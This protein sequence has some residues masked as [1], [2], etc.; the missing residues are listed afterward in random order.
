ML[1]LAVVAVYSPSITG[2]RPDPPGRRGMGRAT[3]SIVRQV[4]TSRIG[5]RRER[6]I[7]NPLVAGPSPAR[8]SQGMDA[9]VA[10]RVD[11]GPRL[12]RQAVSGLRTESASRLAL[13][14]PTYDES[15]PPGCWRRRPAG[16]SL[17]SWDVRLAQR[18]VRTF[19]RRIKSLSRWRTPNLESDPSPV[20]VAEQRNTRGSRG[21]GRPRSQGEA[22]RLRVAGRRRTQLRAGRDSSVR[23]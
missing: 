5:H 7:G 19:E 15:A 6:P 3:K 21:S 23:L 18:R 22:S 12:H 2:S 11:V 8:P 10:A 1:G 14:C 9:L 13:G 4:K 20:A 16:S 17:R